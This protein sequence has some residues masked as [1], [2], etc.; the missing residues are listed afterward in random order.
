MQISVGKMSISEILKKVEGR[1][2]VITL[3][4]GGV[5]V[6]PAISGDSVK[7]DNSEL[8]DFLSSC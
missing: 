7:V 5:E 3:E 6:K 2:T 4:N 1:G 8:Q